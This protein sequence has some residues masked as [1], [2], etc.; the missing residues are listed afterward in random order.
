MQLSEPIPKPNIYLTPLLLPDCPGLWWRD[1]GMYRSMTNVVFGDDVV[2]FSVGDDR[3]VTIVEQHGIQWWRVVPCAADL[4]RPNV[5]AAIAS[6]RELAATLA[7]YAGLKAT[8][9]PCG[10]D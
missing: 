5:L 6:N 4:T 8:A 1:N 9:E 7:Q 10:I 3:A 2:G